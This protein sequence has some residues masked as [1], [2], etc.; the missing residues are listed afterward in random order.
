MYRSRFT[1]TSR[2]RLTDDDFGVTAGHRADPRGRMRS[3]GHFY[4]ENLE[5]DYQYINLN[6]C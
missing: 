6:R 4:R 1:G 5:N 3:K 2:M